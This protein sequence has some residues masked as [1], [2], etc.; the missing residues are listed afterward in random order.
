MRLCKRV[1]NGAAGLQSLCLSVSDG[2]TTLLESS[3]ERFAPGI[4]MLRTTDKTIGAVMN[5]LGYNEY[6]RQYIK[7][8]HPELLKRKT[9]AKRCVKMPA[10]VQKY[11]KAISL[12]ETTSDQIKDIAERLGLNY[13]SLRKYMYKHH[14]EVLKG[15][16]SKENKSDNDHD[17]D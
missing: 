5:E 15:R 9:V 16:R 11:A 17:E 6:F 8:N 1:A 13:S 10:I 4:D 7:A 2:A 14:P 3:A 12:L